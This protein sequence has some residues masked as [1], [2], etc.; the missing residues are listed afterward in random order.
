MQR[1]LLLVT[2]LTIILSVGLLWS[3]ADSKP[4]PDPKTVLVEFDK[5]TITKGD[6]DAKIAKIPP[7]YQ[8]RYKTINGQ[9]EILQGIILEDVFYRKA[10]DLGLDKKKEIADKVDNATR[11][12]YIESYY[13]QEVRDQVAAISNKDKQ[14][15]YMSHLDEFYEQPN[16][17]ILYIQA[18]DQ[19]SA[20]KALTELKSGKAWAEVSNTYNKNGYAKNNKG[21]IKGIRNNGHVPGVNKNEALSKLINDA[22]VSQD[23][24][25]GPEVIDGVYHIFKVTDRI[26]GY[27]K[28]L[29]EVEPTLEKRVKFEKEKTLTKAL[30][31]RLAT[32]YNLVVDDELAGSLDLTTPVTD[33]EILKK[34]VISSD[35]AKLNLTVENVYEVLAAMS[36]QEKAMYMKATGDDSFF[37]RYPTQ[38]LYM[39]E[40]E[41]NGKENYV[42][43]PDRLRQISR[44]FVLRAVYKQLVTD[45][46][47]VTDE[48]LQKY[49]D[50]S[51]ERYKVPGH[52]SIRLYKFDEEK[53]AKKAYKAIR[54]AMKKKNPLKQEAAIKKAYEK[55][56][57]NTFEDGFIAKVYNNNMVLGYGKDVDFNKLV[58]STPLNGTT[59]PFKSSNGDLLVFTV[60]ENVEDTYRPLDEVKQAI[61]KNAKQNKEKAF[62]DE[63]KADLMA[64]YQYKVYA[65]RLTVK[66]TVEELFE[67]ADNAIKQ[68]KYNDSVIYYDQIIKSF[69]D[70]VNDYKAMFMKAFTYSENIKDKAKAIECYNEFL[71]K[72]PTG[73]LNESAKFML[74]QL[75]NGEVNIDELIEN[76]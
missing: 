29:E 69:K 14:Q 30:F 76:E 53:K 56:A 61:E 20:E 28:T 24:I 54:K 7:Q 8:N 36:P 10:I 9:E 3:V 46:I 50:E 1:K 70:G 19:E 67:M 55:Y 63:V 18:E 68:R 64:E 65:D 43:E 57:V 66:L 15:Y 62:R 16:T 58:F 22:Q 31:D 41:E 72:Y 13:R 73:E 34:S 42:D 59:E 37:K 47:D 26:E 33:N 74:D 48:D 75:Q 39:A 21:V 52:R 51:I 60:L 25:H 11:E 12:I 17:T 71:A 6:L 35:Y 32:K 27:Q 44:Y 40:V 38:L 4:N 45:K 5:G 23:K 49:Y 2:L